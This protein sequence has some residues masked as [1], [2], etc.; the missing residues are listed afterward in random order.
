MKLSRFLAK[1]ILGSNV[2]TAVTLASVLDRGT[3]LASHQSHFTSRKEIRYPLNKRLVGSG[4]YGRLCRR[5]ICY[6]AVG[7]CT[8]L[9]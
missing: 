8:E 1:G 9:G 6:M 7:L 4:S 3:Y 2:I 5:Q